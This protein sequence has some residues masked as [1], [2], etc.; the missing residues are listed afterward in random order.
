VDPS[1]DALVDYMDNFFGVRASRREAWEDMNIFLN[2]CAKLNVPITQDKIQFAQGVE[3]LGI[4]FDSKR[5]LYG[6][7]TRNVQILSRW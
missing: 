6:S 7:P 2:L 3:F 4:F 5:W 1:K